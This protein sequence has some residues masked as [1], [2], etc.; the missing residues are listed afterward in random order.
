MKVLRYISCLAGLFFFLSCGTPAAVVTEAEPEVALPSNEEAVALVQSLA[1]AQ[2]QGV[3]VPFAT[4]A[5]PKVFHFSPDAQSNNMNVVTLAPVHGVWEMVNTVGYPCFEADGTSFKEFTQDAAI[6]DIGGKDFILLKTLRE[7]G[8]GKAQRTVVT[9]EPEAENLQAVSFCG[10]YLSDG[11]I[12][13]NSYI[14]VIASSIN[15]ELEFARNQLVTDPLLVELKKGDEITDQAIQWWLKNNPNA[16]TNARTVSFGALD[17]ESSLVESYK[18]AKKESSANYNAAMFDI[19]GYT[20]VVVQRKS[21]GSYVLAWAEPVCAN[22][23]TDQL[24]NSIYFRNDSNLVLFYYKGR[25]TFNYQLS[26]ANGRLM[27]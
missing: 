24:L 6:Q 11:R 16:Q 17:T 18:K 15:P 12:E 22:K 21:N 7:D 25:R 1:P 13:G 19:R 10:K 14:D 9:F 26:L 23:S 4:E 8:A 2:A 5:G 20:V 27:K 3:T